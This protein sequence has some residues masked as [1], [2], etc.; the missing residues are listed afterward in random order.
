MILLLREQPF[1]F[2]KG[3]VCFLSESE[4]STLSIKLFFQYLALQRME[5]PRLEQ[6]KLFIRNY[7]LFMLLDNF[8]GTLT[9]SLPH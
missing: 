7:S 6:N 1:D 3:V 2:K 5:K 9:T 4:N 8:V